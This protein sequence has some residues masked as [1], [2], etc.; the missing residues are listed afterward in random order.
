ME[1]PIHTMLKPIFFI[2]FLAMSIMSLFLGLSSAMSIDEAVALAL[3]NN[4]DLQS[5]QMN[6][7]IE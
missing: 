1:S 3:N 4:P 2:L 7:M 6:Q 5:K